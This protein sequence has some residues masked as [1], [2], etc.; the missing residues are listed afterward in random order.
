MQGRLVFV[1]TP[2]ADVVQDLA[3]YHRGY[4]VIWNPPCNRFRSPGSI[5]CPIL[6]M[7]SPLWRTLPIR[8]VRLT[9]HLIVIRSRLLPRP[10]AAFALLTPST[11]RNSSPLS[12]ARCG[13]AGRPQHTASV[14][15]RFS[16]PAAMKSE[17]SSFR[18]GDFL[19]V[20]RPDTGRTERSRTTGSLSLIVHRRR[21]ECGTVPA[22]DA[23]LCS[24]GIDGVTSFHHESAD[25]APSRHAGI[26]FGGVDHA[27]RREGT[28][29]GAEPDRKSTIRFLRSP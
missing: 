22:A 2:L 1:R 24:H 4:I 27:P 23:H 14:P 11:Y 13:L 7:S 6:L 20:I 15:F 16:I 18:R 17:S 19:F 21:F 25:P 12:F 28:N 3:R 29:A 5:I 26:H 10:P 9:D 8:M